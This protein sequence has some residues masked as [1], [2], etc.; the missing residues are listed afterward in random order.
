MAAASTRRPSNLSDPA[1]D[2]VVNCAANTDLTRI[3]RGF[4]VL[5]AAG[6]VRVTTHQGTDCVLSAVPAGVLIPLMCQRIWLTNTTATLILA[7]F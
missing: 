1:D 7:L 6:D 2:C 5:G 3:C 4:I